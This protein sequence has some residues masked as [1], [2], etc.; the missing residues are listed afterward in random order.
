MSLGLYNGGPRDVRIQQVPS[1]SFYYWAFD[2]MAL[3]TEQPTGYV[4]VAGHYRPFRPFT[5]HRG[6]TKNVRLEFHLAACDPAGLQAGGSS[7]LLSLP[8]T[9]RTLGV[10]RT[11]AVPF[12]DVVVAVQAM[13]TCD[14]PV[15]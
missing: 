8:L 15:R 12:R 14:Q 1:Q 7:S 4:G 11:V 13:G 5:L 10:T 3:D 2:R 6:E 9:Y